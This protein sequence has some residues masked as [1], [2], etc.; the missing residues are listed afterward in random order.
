MSLTDREV[1]ARAERIESLLGRVETIADVP[2][3]ELALS[4]VQALVDLYGEGLARIVEHV[5]ASDDASLATALAG[6]ELV[7]HLLLLHGL[8]PDDTETRV[9]RALEG[10]RPS[11]RSHGADVVL[12]AIDDGG[13]QLRIETTRSG[14]ASTAATLRQTVEDAVRAAAPELDRVAVESA[15]PP[16][17][18]VQLAHPRRASAG[19]GAGALA[20][21]P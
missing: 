4:A 13:A 5:A 18:L 21:A 11:L 9:E 17:P 19:A 15:A 2:A 10:A 1:R 12:V 20:A 8:H 3:R 16:P 14:C 6:D 7:S